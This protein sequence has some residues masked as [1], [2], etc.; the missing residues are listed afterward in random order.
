MKKHKHNFETD[1]GQCTICGRTVADLL[2]EK[3][4]KKRRKRL[5]ALD[6]DNDIPV[7]RD[8]ESISSYENRTGRGFWGNPSSGYVFD[9]DNR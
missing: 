5:R 3:Q 6:D 9:K 4:D 2:E 7:V 1:G 8:S